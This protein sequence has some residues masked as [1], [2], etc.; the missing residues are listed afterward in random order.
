MNEVE[1]NP[2]R[3]TMMLLLLVTIS[4]NISD[5]MFFII[6]NEDFSSLPSQWLVVG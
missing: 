1:V 2:L 6:D 4:A 5:Q 3:M